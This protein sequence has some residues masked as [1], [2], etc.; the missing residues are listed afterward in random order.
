[1]CYSDLALESG[2]GL[3]EWIASW[4]PDEAAFRRERAEILLYPEAEAPA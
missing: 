1:M 3:E 4:S 2:A